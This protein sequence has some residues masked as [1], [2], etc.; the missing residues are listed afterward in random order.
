MDAVA[1]MRAA[2]HPIRRRLLTLLGDGEET[3]PATL[4][5]EIPGASLGTVAYHVQV[6]AESGL[7][8]PTRTVDKGGVTEHFYRLSP[9]GR[10]V[11]EAADAL[12]RALS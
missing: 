2:G 6:L 11:L 8:A 3:S 5:A 4:A 9:A 10:T 1:A 7:I 12:E